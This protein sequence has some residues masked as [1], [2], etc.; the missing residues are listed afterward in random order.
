MIQAAATDRELMQKVKE[1]DDSA[2]EELV[3]RYKKRLFNV[4]YRLINDR[5]EAEDILQ[6]TF[7]RVYRERESYDPTYCFSTWVYTIALNLTKN[8][9]KKRSVRSTQGLVNT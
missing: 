5:S 2:F 1:R 9:L 4:I 3:D 8:E 7:L 6:E